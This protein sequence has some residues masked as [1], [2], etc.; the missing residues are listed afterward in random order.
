MRPSLP[1]Y[2]HQ[3]KQFQSTHPVWGATCT[4]SKT[5][6]TKLLFQSTH[7]VWG[8]TGG[9]GGVVHHMAISIHAPRVGCDWR[10]CGQFHPSRRIS[11]HAP[12]VGCDGNTKLPILKDSLISIHAP[13]VGCDADMIYFPYLPAYFNPRTPCGVRQV[14]LEFVQVVTLISIHAP[15]VGCDAALHSGPVGVINISIHAPRVGCDIQ[16]SGAHQQARISI[17]APRVGCDTRLKPKFRTKWN[18]NPR[19]PCGVRHMGIIEVDETDI[20]QSTHPVWGA[21][22]V[23]TLAAK[24]PFI[25]IHAPRVGCDRCLPR[26]C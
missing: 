20:F 9:V 3:P 24:T 18:F 6:S 21:T 4:A 15:R 1:C 7:P 16:F 26:H 14:F 8:A 17:H 22:D 2:P 5:S 25:S 12:R 11:I 19:T 23:A 10:R 13:R